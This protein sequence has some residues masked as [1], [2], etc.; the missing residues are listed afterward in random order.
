MRMV[1]LNI[2]LLPTT[3]GAGK[4]TD[5]QMRLLQRKRVFYM[6]TRWHTCDIAQM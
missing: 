2:G 6:H 5:V 3:A 1:S 4:G